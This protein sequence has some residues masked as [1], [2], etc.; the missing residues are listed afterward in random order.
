[1]TTDP[2]TADPDTDADE[3]IETMMSHGFRHLPVLEDG[4]VA[5]VVSLRD[6]VRT[7]I[8]RAGSQ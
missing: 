6:I 1:M 5:G 7:R 2:V 3:A 8:W 4:R